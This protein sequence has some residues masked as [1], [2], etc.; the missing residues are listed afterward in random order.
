MHPLH[1]YILEA[2]LTQ[3]RLMNAILEIV[4]PTSIGLTSKPNRAQRA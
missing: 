4:Q 2:E 1:V 3:N